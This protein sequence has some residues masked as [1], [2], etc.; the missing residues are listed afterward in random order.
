MINPYVASKTITGAGSTAG[1]F[2]ILE[3]LAFDEAN[4]SLYTLEQGH[5]HSISRFD[6]NGNPVPFSGLGGASSITT[7]SSGGFE[8]SAGIAVDNSPG[9]VG[10]F[11]VVR[12]EGV[13]LRSWSLSGIARP[14]FTPSKTGGCG[15]DVDPDGDPWVNNGGRSKVVEIDGATGL[16]T[17]IE[18]P[19]GYE[20]GCGVKIDSKGNF[21]VLSDSLDSIAKVT[22]TGT[23]KYYLDTRGHSVRGI[24]I[25][26][27]TDELFAVVKPGFFTGS[28]IFRYG[29]DSIEPVE[30][31]GYPDAGH[32]DPDGLGSARSIAINSA[33]H[34]I[35]VS[36][37]GS[38]ERYSLGSPVTVPTVE[39][40]AAVPTPTTAVL[41]GSVDPDGVT[42]T[43][44]HF[45]WGT[46]FEDSTYKYE[47]SVP[48][49]EGSALGGSGA[50]SV[51]A[52]VSG[53]SRGATYHFRLVAENGNGFAQRTEDTTFIAQDLPAVSDEHVRGVHTESATADALVD[54]EAGLAKVEVEFG[55]DTSYGRSAPPTPVATPLG[56][57]P[58]RVSLPIEGLK[59]ETEYHYRVVATNAAGKTVSS[60]DHHF[61]TFA[62][63][64]L[65]NERCVNALARQ[66]TGAAHLLDCRAYELVSAANT[67]GYNVESGLVPGQHPFGG[68]P[69][70][71][72]R[73]LYGVHDGGI[74]GTGNPTNH[75]VDPY[76]AT[77]SETG[78]HTTYVGIPSNGAPL[79]S[80]FASPL[81]A[82]DDSLSTFAFGGPDI[83]SPCFASGSTGVP[84]RRAD[85]AL[86]QGMAG[87]MSPGAPAEGDGAIAKPLSAD[88]SHL[89]FGAV[90]AFQADGNNE[91]GDVSIY[92]R[93][94]ETGITQVVSKTPQGTNLPCLQG[95]GSCH[96][97]GNPAGIAELDISSD[98]SRVVVAQRVSTD[99]RGNHHWHPYM[100]V[101]NSPNTV[102]LAPGTTSGV[103][104]DG[105]TADG[106]RVFLTTGDQ[107]L[108]ED[109]DASADIYEATVN[110]GGT[111]SL[112]LV[113]TN[114]DGSPENSDACT[115]IGNWN[116]VAG[117]PS[118]GAV[119]VAGGGGVAAGEGSFYF[120]SP[121]QLEGSEGQ[122]GQAN[123]YLVRPGEAPRFA[124]TVGSNVGREGPLSHPVGRP[125]LIG[126]LEA[127][128][129]VELDRLTGDI[130][131]KE[132]ASGKV[133]RFTADG[134]PKNFTAGPDVETNAL[135]VPLG[136]AG[137]GQMAVD[138]HQGSPF[139][140][141]LYATTEGQVAVFAPSG[142]KLG[143][144]K[145]FGYACGIAADPTSGAVYVGDYENT[146]WRLAPI[147]NPGSGVTKANYTVTQIHPEMNPCQ[148]AVDTA[149]NVYASNY[150][151][152]PVKRFA[153]ATFAPEPGPNVSGTTITG[154]ANLLA[155]DPSTNYLYVT[156]G[157]RIDIFDTAGNFR[158]TLIEDGVTNASGVAVDGL[159]HTAYVSRGFEIVELLYDPVA[160]PAAT[161]GVVQPGTR[162][163]SDFQVTP[164]GRYAVFSSVLPLTGYGSGNH[165]Q[166]FRYDAG[167][168]DV[169]CPSC[170]LTNARATGDATLAKR[171]L[172]VTEDGRVFFN[173]PDPLV[174][175]DANGLQDA[176]EWSAG[177]PQL[178]STG[179]SPFDSELLSVSASGG[180]A[181]FFTRDVLSPQDNNGTLMKVY[182]ARAD[183]GYFKLAEATSLR[184]IG[185]VSRPWH[186]ACATRAECLQ[187]GN[188][189]Q[190]ADRQALQEGPSQERPE[191]RQAKEAADQAQAKWR[192]FEWLNGRRTAARR[193]PR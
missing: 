96:S 92:E 36:S 181:Y 47:Q 56:D 12:P 24:A 101:G 139:Q 158:E 38:A 164:D 23:I 30:A 25:D 63:V 163:T 58:F 52:P 53:L 94:L 4:E 102:D 178:I 132:R 184:G 3:F 78:W 60:D 177:I 31:F 121:E 8:E 66:Q 98:G 99:V 44:C 144:I 133:L 126:N 167:S 168:G 11:Y 189:G 16:P 179:T 88:G 15:V 62:L 73:V 34:D 49:A 59:P 61:T 83:C 190:R 79:S 26:R 159:T 45:E 18:R 180:D 50:T 93:N 114:S 100:H 37:P 151:E 90:K 109:T 175:G 108:G 48:C 192:A 6:P 154:T 193:R 7:G 42:T 147:S 55:T 1:E 89:V 74:P 186:G 43:D 70:A 80:P 65:S 29:P 116:V 46:T 77:R 69:L 95:A 119:A 107:L 148:V 173:S 128:E 86:V 156:T 143:D 75:G 188:S 51:T 191:M 125:N 152:G 138:S 105:M 33:N 72:G 82:A 41:H 185:R 135:S 28:K 174:L 2:Q 68:Y 137:E 146:I 150:L 122:P 84:V 40:G 140:S 106:T 160:S 169:A 118:C 111:A 76:L 10:D 13:G 87:A 165:Q 187:D 110:G 127:P 157:G 120:F 85:G 153:T 81:L 14:A 35:Y 67:G 171:G 183:G 9:S 134:A 117:G 19:T 32:G 112:R 57:T 103:L 142:E 145:G 172:S 22:P 17:D 20:G 104:Y 162:E 21:Y 71:D 64:D 161:N 130:W 27:S 123:M 182:D 97:P 115:P 5:Q 39:N 113:T 136:G 141:A 166:I 131:V 91:S 129:T 54:P 149:G 124:V 170:I 155:V 176:Y